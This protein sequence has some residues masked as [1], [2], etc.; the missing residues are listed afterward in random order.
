ML[1]RSLAITIGQ[2]TYRYRY[3]FN[4]F[5]YVDPDL[6]SEFIRPV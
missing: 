1:F 5:K 2:V 3:H 4:V 6:Y